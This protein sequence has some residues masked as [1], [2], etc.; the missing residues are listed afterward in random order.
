MCVQ[1]YAF[2]AN[3]NTH[4][5][6]AQDKAVSALQKS[7]YLKVQTT[8]HSNTHHVKMRSPIVV[9]LI[10]KPANQTPYG[11]NRGRIS[12]GVHVNKTHRN[13]N[14]YKN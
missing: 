11:T 13:K 2:V 10:A 5:L 9:N 6:C 12:K 7:A 4:G 8:Q 3:E 1:S 14:I